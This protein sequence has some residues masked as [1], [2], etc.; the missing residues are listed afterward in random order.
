MT[1]DQEDRCAGG[2]GVGAGAGAGATGGAVGGADDSP[3]DVSPSV[4]EGDDSL[5]E[6]GLVPEPMGVN[7][8]EITNMVIQYIL[9]EFRIIRV[10]GSVCC[11]GE[12]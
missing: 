11:C 3:D 6:L 5:L 8:L 4:S 1:N 12:N 2:A 7:I 9:R 10:P